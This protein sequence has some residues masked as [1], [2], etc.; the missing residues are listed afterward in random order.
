[1]A[2]MSKAIRDEL[3]V[4]LVPVRAGER[5]YGLGDFLAIQICFGIAAWFFLVGSLT[6]LTVRSTESAAA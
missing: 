6:G 3:Y 1:M 5:I 4:N 2:M